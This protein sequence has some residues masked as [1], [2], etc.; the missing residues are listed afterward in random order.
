MA[1]LSSSRIFG[2]KAVYRV[3]AGLV[4]FVAAVS[5]VYLGLDAIMAVFGWLGL[6]ALTFTEYVVPCI[7]ALTSAVI[8][9]AVKRFRGARDVLRTKIG[10]RRAKAYTVDSWEGAI[11]FLSDIYARVDADGEV[12]AQDDS[13]GKLLTSCNNSKDITEALELDRPTRLRKAIRRVH[14]SGDPEHH[15]LLG[16]TPGSPRSAWY[17]IRLV[18]S[19]NATGRFM[20]DVVARNITQK[21][22]AEL[23][24]RQSEEKYRT[25]VE[26][27]K[28]LL[29]HLTAEGYISFANETTCYYAG[30]DTPECIGKRLEDLTHPEDRLDVAARVRAWLS[31]ELERVVIESR[32]LGRDDSC[33]HISWELVRVTDDT[34]R[35]VTIEVAGRDITELVAVRQQSDQRERWT[36]ALLNANT[37]AML[38]MSREGWVLASNQT[39]AEMSGLTAQGFKGLNVLAGANISNW[40]NEVFKS[41]VERAREAIG[42]ARPVLCGDRIGNQCFELHYY[43]QLDRSGQV[44]CLAILVRDVTPVRQMLDQLKRSE[45]KYQELFN[46]VVEGLGLVDENEIIQY[47]NPALARMLGETSPDALVGQSL[48]DYVEP[49]ERKLLRSQTQDRRRG[50]ST[51]YE[52]AL[53]RT[54]GENIIAMA[55]VSPKFN[56]DGEYVG[57][58]GCVIDIT[59]RHEAE[60]LLRESEERHRTIIESAP[61][62]IMI[63][64]LDKPQCLHVNKAMCDLSGYSARELLS[65]ELEKFLPHNVVK[66]LHST[67]DGSVETLDPG[68]TEF[69]LRRKDGSRIAV[70]FKIA[71]TIIDGQRVAVL[72]LRN[73]TREVRRE[74]V[75]RRQKED[76]AMLSRRL[77]TVQEEE[78]SRV[79]HILHDSIVQ[80]LVV[81]KAK[82]EGAALNTPDH[83]D[84]FKELSE[85]ISGIIAD[86]R[87]MSSDLRPRILDKEGLVSAVRWYIGCFSHRI[88]IRLK[89]HGEERPL[90]T[91]TKTNVF[92]TIQEIVSN[93]LK[94]SQATTVSITIQFTQ[95]ALTIQAEDNGV[96]LDPASIGAGTGGLGLL[97]I[98]ERVELERGEMIVNALPGKGMSFWIDIPIEGDAG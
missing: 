1:K 24:L 45:E 9:F 30:L 5:V 36:Q 32:C 96:G 15:V 47:C 46:G 70:R 12:L 2:S 61:D 33:Y 22:W 8:V 65:V 16:G 31:S 28:T 81:I 63:V 42:S 64:S 94:H 14:N 66:Y 79:A 97:H 73:V 39:A 29:V 34:E 88:Q 13:L 17:D 62:A 7:L 27:S 82:L 68:T 75:L 84:Y 98:T 11:R 60:R 83:C 72:F 80:E 55:S 89:V 41:R 77:L 44:T 25:L 10:A 59:K 26:H 58:F 57:A 18:R 91:H 74:V 37:D 50:V 95:S 86:L 43:P 6:D 38:L 90:P 49:K 56:R 51:T 78:R 76:L 23:A 48:L 92:R 53:R 69:R 19:R 40:P 67:I 35:V 71:L 85:L 93:A 87:R 21:H 3:S 4:L 20:V 54:D 52:I